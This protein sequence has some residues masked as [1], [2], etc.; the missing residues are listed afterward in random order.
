[1]VPTLREITLQHVGFLLISDSI[2]RLKVG[3][4]VK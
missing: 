1:M 3:R 2:D 4:E